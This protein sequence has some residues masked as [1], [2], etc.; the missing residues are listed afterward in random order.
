MNLGARPAKGQPLRRFSAS[1]YAVAYIGYMHHYP[2]ALIHLE[3]IRKAAGLAEDTEVRA[4]AL[5]LVARLEMDYHL[6][7]LSRSAM[8]LA[9]DAFRGLPGTEDSINALEAMAARGVSGNAP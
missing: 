3:A 5:E 7:R 2:S 4:T 1:R 9:L 8:L 6:Q